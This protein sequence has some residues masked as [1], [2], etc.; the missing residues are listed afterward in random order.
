[1]E[2]FKQNYYWY[3]LYTRSRTE[4]KVEIEL[5]H[6]DITL[7][8]PMRKTLRQW[9]DRKKWVEVPLFNSY[10]FVYISEKQYLDVLRT[11]NA[12]RFVTFEGKAV[13]IPLQQ[14][15]AVK[16]FI[17]QGT[18]EFNEEIQILE[19]GR[20][21]EITKGPMMGLHGILISVAG[22]HRVKVEIECVG[23]SLIIDVPKTSLREI[24]EF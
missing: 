24:S 22:K 3:A 17:E 10:I 11:P 4:K 2:T 5:R 6:R 18:P 14:I 20:N 9:S 1:M 19:S 8:L 23:K 13:P 21:I 7:F 16:A 15:E 12:V